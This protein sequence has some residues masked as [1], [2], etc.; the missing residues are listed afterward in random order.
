MSTLALLGAVAAMPLTASAQIFTDSNFL[1]ADYTTSTFG[2]VTD[3]DFNVDYSDIDVFGDGFLTASLPEAP[4][5]TGGTATTGVFL[6][7]NN[8]SIALGGTGT[9][10][11]AAI[12]PNDVN[13]G[14]GTDS[15]NFVMQVDVF[16]STGPGVD[17]GAGNQDFTGTTNY[18]YVGINQANTTLRIQELNAS[19]TTGQGVGLAITADTGAA[20]DY[21][22]HY[23]GAGYRFRS[24]IGPNV[25]GDGTN[26]RSGQADNPDLRTGLVGDAINDAWLGEAAAVDTFDF[27]T[28]VPENELNQFSGDSLYF[29][30]DPTD[31]NSFISDG[32]GVDRSYFAEAFPVHDDPLVIAA[33]IDPAFPLGNDLG[34]A[35]VPYNRWATHRVYYIDGVVSYTIE[36]SVLGV[37]TLVLEQAINDPSDEGDDTVFDDTSDAGSIVLGFWD[38]FG[39]SIALSPEGANFV[40]YDN[41]I[42]DEAT[43]GDVTSLEAAIA[44]FVPLVEGGGIIGDYDDSGQVEQGDLNLVLNNWGTAAPFDPNGDPFETTNVDQEELNRVLNNWGSTTA[45]SFEGAAVPEPATVAVLGGLA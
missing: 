28:G 17:D 6:T 8:D 23:G 39:G 21:L 7:V 44:D 19:E 35:G 27:G 29:S 20:E 13:V 11:F 14:A 24:G 30:P 1:A 42:I 40:V 10:S 36:D 9:E 43:A 41:L 37:E 15:P 31:P 32:S 45:P 4:N 33:D 16:H 26:F 22:P 5:S 34:T 2:T 38:R 3:I 12:I 25:A 18:S